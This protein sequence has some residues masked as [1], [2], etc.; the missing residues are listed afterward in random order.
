MCSSQLCHESTLAP[1]HRNEDQKHMTVV[2]IQLSKQS[3]TSAFTALKPGAAIVLQLDSYQSAQ[4]WRDQLAQAVAAV[5]R[6]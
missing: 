2:L 6:Q 4:L 1:S 5:H 3:V